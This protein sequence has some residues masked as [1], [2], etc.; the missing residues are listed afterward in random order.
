MVRSY[1]ALGTKMYL[2]WYAGGV[3]LKVAGK[4]VVTAAKSVGFGKI[5]SKITQSGLGFVSKNLTRTS[6]RACLSEV[7]ALCQKQTSRDLELIGL[8]IRGKSPCGRFIE[9]KDRFGNIRVKIH[10][11][12]ASFSE[13][14]T[15]L[16]GF[17]RST[18]QWMELKINRVR[19]Q[20]E[21]NL[22]NQDN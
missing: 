19:M 18:G 21:F 14:V 17:G 4:V 22:K 8:K 16:C 13:S 11:P 9:F 5:T 12:D 3:V 2:T 20:A 7:T 10:P 6:I 1:L 15:C